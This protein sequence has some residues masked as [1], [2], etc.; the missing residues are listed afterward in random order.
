VI[1]R[2]AN[3][4]ITPEERYVKRNEHEGDLIAINSRSL[5][6]LGRWLEACTS[7]HL[8]TLFRAEPDKHKQ[9]NSAT[10]VYSSNAKFERLT[11]RSV[12]V[13]GL[14]ALLAP[15]WW[16]EF[17]SDSHKRLGII[18]GFICVFISIISVATHNRPFEV[19]AATAAYAAVLM[20]FMQIGGP[21]GSGSPLPATNATSQG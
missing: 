8:S 19:V 5:P 12:I 16:L 20:V 9:V 1:A 17:V 11:T 21:S 4:A 6:P 14:I 3:G 15:M 13:T 18:T 7:F 2:L 10:T